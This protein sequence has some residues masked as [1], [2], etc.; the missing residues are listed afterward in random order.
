MFIAVRRIHS[1]SRVTAPV[2]NQKS[3]PP[4]AQREELFAALDELAENHMTLQ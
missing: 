1:S 3:S 2:R 4:R